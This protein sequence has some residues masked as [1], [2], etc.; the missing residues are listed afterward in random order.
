[1]FDPETTTAFG[2]MSYRM[3]FLRISRCFARGIFGAI[4]E[5]EEEEEEAETDETEDFV[6]NSAC[7]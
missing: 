5:E 2:F 7:S 1:M 3:L 6:R 4:A